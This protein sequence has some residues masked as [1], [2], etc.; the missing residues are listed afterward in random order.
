MIAVCVRGSLTLDGT[1]LKSGSY[2]IDTQP[3][4]TVVIKSGT[5]E[6]S[7][8]KQG[9]AYGV[10]VQT[11]DFTMMGGEIKHTAGGD[12]AVFFVDGGGTISGGTITA[13]GCGIQL[14][15]SSSV[16]LSG[17]PA[18]KGGKADI[19][20]NY[21]AITVGAGLTGKYTVYKTNPS[22]ITEPSPFPFTTASN[23][24]HS[25][26][27]S[28]A[29]TG[30]AGLAS[31]TA[32]RGTRRRWSCTASMGTAASGHMT[33]TNIGK[34]ALIPTAPR[35]KRMLRTTKRSGRWAIPSTGRRV[36]CATG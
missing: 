15:T 22:S 11:A 8:T 25:A 14:A 3:G 28:P 12:A 24:D 30:M 32:A 35:P 4:S 36:L 34:R 31:E 6:S 16:T 29:S 17:S 19:G 5:V 10:N 2:A 7:N 1:V 9:Q 27:F 23:A 13:N 26:L 33:P 20:V 21:G 18:I